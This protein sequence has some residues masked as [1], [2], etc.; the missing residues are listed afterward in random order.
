MAIGAFPISRQPRCSLR[1]DGCTFDLNR[2][3]SIEHHAADV[4]PQ[5]LCK[6]MSSSAAAEAAAGNSGKAH[7]AAAFGGF[8]AGVF[9]ASCVA[10]AGEVADG[11]H[12]AS[13]PWPHEG[14]FD[15]YDHA[16]IRRGHQVYTQVCAQGGVLLFGGNAPH[17]I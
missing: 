11:L 10:S 9:G 1:C 3:R 13:Y 14:I 12:A 5:A 6:A 16:S 4:G 15:S 2:C 17:A 7:Y 8:L